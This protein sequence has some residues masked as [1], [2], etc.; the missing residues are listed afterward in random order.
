MRKSG[1]CVHMQIYFGAF[2]WDLGES[3]KTL[4]FKAYASKWEKKKKNH[5]LQSSNI[6]VFVCEYTL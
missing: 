5:A 3:E 6:F 4:K 2:C 1:A